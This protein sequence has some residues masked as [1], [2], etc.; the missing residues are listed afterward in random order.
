MEALYLECS[1]EEKDRLVAELW[2]R[3]TRG[4]IEREAAGGRY[5]LEAFFDERF[6]AEEL[7]AYGPRWETAEERNWVRLIMESWRP[8]PVG[9][10]FFVVPDWR[11]DAT[12]PGRLRL[13]VH[14]GIALGTGEHPTTQMCLEAMERE[15]RAGECFFDVGTGSGILAQAA[16]LLGARRV[17]ACDTDPQATEAAGENLGR[18]G[19]PA[20]LFTGSAA[21]VADRVAAVAAA[22]LSAETV[23]EAA[24]EIARVLEEGGRAVLSGFG[25]ERSA[26]V[27]RAAEGAGMRFLGGQ[28]RDGW[29]CL[30]VVRNR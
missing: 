23:V 30:V 4:I 15:L 9:E 29:A 5:E 22:N 27:R 2:E 28:E 3:G 16:W 12:P 1:G 21:A 20:L 17:I 8:F 13:E 19:V 25:P 24:G 10:R 7:A 14:P 26:E 6:G 11:D 18:A